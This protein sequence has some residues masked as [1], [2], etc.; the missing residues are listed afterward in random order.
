M[1]WEGGECSPSHP[2]CVGGSGTTSS[3]EVSTS[4]HSAHDHGDTCLGFGIKGHINAVGRR[5][6]R[7]AMERCNNTI[8]IERFVLGHLYN[9]TCINNTSI[10]ILIKLT[11]GRING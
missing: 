10:S 2:R 8:V 4:C 1:P 11:Y 7:K 6:T 3:S 5:N 9:K